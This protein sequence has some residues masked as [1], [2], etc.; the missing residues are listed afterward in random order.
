MPFKIH[1]LI[2]WFIFFLSWYVFWTI[3]STESNNF[4]DSCEAYTG[5][6]DCVGFG[7]SFATEY[8]YFVIAIDADG[9]EGSQSNSAYAVTLPMGGTEDDGSDDGTG[10]T[11]DFADFSQKIIK[12]VAEIPIRR[13][14]VDNLLNKTNENMSLMQLLIF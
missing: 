11:L 6:G 4:I 2:F 1:I 5:D 9:N 10:G 14:V 7:L 13:E 3:V 8:E 12:S